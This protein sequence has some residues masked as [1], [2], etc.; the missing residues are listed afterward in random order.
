MIS[1]EQVEAVLSDIRP[2]LQADGLNIEVMSME[3]DSA[4]AHLT[5]PVDASPGVLLTLWSGLEEGLRARIPGFDSLRS[6]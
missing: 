5:L 6:S 3:G 1:T 4:L 2:F